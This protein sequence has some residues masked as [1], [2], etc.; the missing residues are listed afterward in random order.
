MKTVFKVA[1]GVFLGI[2]AAFGVY[3]VYQWWAGRQAAKLVFEQVIQQAQM[4]KE[5]K[6]KA[7][8][9]MRKITPDKMV[10]LCGTPM[11]T[12]KSLGGLFAMHYIGNDHH[13]IEV[14]FTCINS[15]DPD[16]CNLLGM[17]KERTPDWEKLGGDYF[18]ASWERKRFEQKKAAKIADLP[19]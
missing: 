7:A 16:A 17:K 3:M 13:E 8:K 2:M 5:A 12:G 4:E 6:E 15:S 1:A 14:T 11:R 10:S 9:N 18:I 19:K